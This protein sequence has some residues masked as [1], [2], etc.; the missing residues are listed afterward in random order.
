MTQFA[1]FVLSAGGSPEM[2]V[3]IHIERNYRLLEKFVK[4]IA[5]I[6]NEYFLKPLYQAYAQDP[7]EPEDSR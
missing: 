1:I 6:L 2:D 4:V 7:L 5:F 3:C